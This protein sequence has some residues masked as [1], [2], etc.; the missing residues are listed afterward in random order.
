MREAI[1]VRQH[2]IYDKKFR[3][4]WRSTS[5]YRTVDRQISSFQQKH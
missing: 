2:S 4:S 1:H 3:K 5:R